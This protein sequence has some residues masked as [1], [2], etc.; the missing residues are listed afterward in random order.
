MPMYITSIVR[1]NNVINSLTLFM[2]NFSNKLPTNKTTLYF[3]R[4]KL[5]D[6]IRLALRSNSL[7][8]L[9]Q[10]L[11][12]PKLDS[13]I[14]A[15]VLRST[16]SLD[17]ALSLTEAL[18]AIPQFRH[19]QHTLY[20]LVRVLA[21]SQQ[22]QKLKALINGINSGMFPNVPRVSFMEAIKL[23]STAGDLDSV[24][25]FCEKWR[26]S[27][28]RP[29]AETYNML[30]CQYVRIG[31]NEEAVKVFENMVDEGVVPNSRT[32]TVMIEHLVKLG[33]FDSSME[34]FTM[35][36]MMKIKRTLRQYT[37]LFE[38]F[39][40]ADNFKM[41]T[42]LL[43]E[44]KIDGKLPGL[45]MLRALQT[46]H[47]AGF[48]EETKE[49]IYGLLP[50]E[51]IKS[52]CCPIEDDPFD[53]D[54]NEY[55]N[56]NGDGDEN[57]VQ[58][59][60]WLD[61]SALASALRNWEPDE[62]SVLEDSK[63]IW[64]SRLVS[65]MIRSFKSA[66]TAFK[67]FCW[68]AH[69]PGFAH[70]VHTYSIMIPKLAPCGSDDSVNEILFKIKN[71]NIRLSI[72]TISMVIDSYGVHKKGQAAMNI[73]REVKSLCGS[74]SKNQKLLLYKSLLRT[75]TKCKM[76]S[77]I[78]DLVDEMVLGNTLPDIQTFTE[79]MHHFAREGDIKAVQRLFSMVKQSNIKPDRY[80]YQV[81]IRAFCER[82][83]A[84]LALRVFEDMLNYDIFPDIVTKQMLVKSLWKEGKLREAA[85]VEERSEDSNS[86]LPLAPRGRSYVISSLNLEKVCKIY[87]QSFSTPD[88]GDN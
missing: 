51:R 81:L 17:S 36:P 64:T 57:V 30:M 77:S 26:A 52:L 66:E 73:F 34:I 16:P 63:I 85:S 19:T 25:S 4:A 28:R 74:I 61:P 54:G 67:F 33:K 49:F 14:V 31:K 22:T 32:Y 5:I 70:G 46:M 7:C 23:Y 1:L 41:A 37:I 20:A 71:E 9:T 86:T 6:S 2:R 8:A 78:L 83:R 38:A 50:D 55:D 69:K 11:N 80:T 13:F 82:D 12:D 10:L 75:M 15:N 68:V 84:V 47:E 88:S 56:F 21:K 45:S 60:P 3:Q 35:L 39:V 53:D 65:K 40:G 42:I 27:E 62:V 43:D 24:I 59:K 79:L 58:L 87:S 18:R 29:C 44:L 48:V 76:N 72:T